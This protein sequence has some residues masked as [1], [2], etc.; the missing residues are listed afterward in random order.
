MFENFTKGLKQGAKQGA[1]AL[2]LLSGA[3]LGLNKLESNALEQVAIA[4]ENQE[5]F[6]KASEYVNSL[7]NV[8]ER[9]KTLAL[10]DVRRQLAQ[11][12]SDI[13]QEDRKKLISLQLGN[14]FGVKLA[15]NNQ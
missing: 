12:S 8:D 4:P 15:E 5:I 3:A 7:K 11:F 13:T 9:V 6:D 2:G 14:R 10:N 1:V